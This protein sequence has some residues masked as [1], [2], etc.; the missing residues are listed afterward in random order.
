VVRAA[1]CT[2]RRRERPDLLTPAARAATRRTKVRC[3]TQWLRANALHAPRDL[4]LGT[5]GRPRFH[6][7]VGERPYRC[8]ASE[9]VH[10]LD[11]EPTP[12]VDGSYGAF[13]R[14]LYTPARH[15]AKGKSDPAFRT[16]LAIGAELAVQAR[17]RGS[18]SGRSW[19]TARTGTR[20][21]SAT[22]SRRPDCRS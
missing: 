9:W 10:G 21:G 6:A 17:R 19:R 13:V 15:V 2:T 20:T 7:A 8:S 5:P 14:T 11:R 3:S 22:N 18:R 4:G 16:K 1:Q 12:W